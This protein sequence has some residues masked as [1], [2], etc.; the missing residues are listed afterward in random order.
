MVSNNEYFAFISY[1]REDEKWAEWLQHKLEHY[2]IPIKVR[3]ENPQL[4]QVIRPVFKDTSELAA[5]VLEEEIHEALVNSKYLIVI[6]S[7]RA[8]QSKWV[9]K[10]VQAFID[11][12]RSEKIIP[13][14]I[15]GTPYS[16]VP[17]EEC[18][19]MALLNLPKEQELLGVNINEMGR[20]AAAVKVVARMF[21]LKFDTLWQRFE[22]ERKK[23]RNI[24]WGSIITF[25]I[26]A[27]CISVW[28]W[29][30]NLMLKEKDMKIMINQSRAISGKA[31][32]LIEEGDSYTARLLLQEIDP[33]SNMFGYSFPYTAAW[34]S[35]LRKAD[36]KNSA[37]LTGHRQEV[38]SIC[39]S[40]DGELIASSDR[41]GDIIVWKASSGAI[42]K[43]IK[44]NGRL[45]KAVA[46]SPDGKLLA[47]GSNDDTIRFFNCETWECND[48]IYV[49]GCYLWAI[50]F[51]PDGKYLLSDSGDGHI[52][53]WNCK[54]LKQANVTSGKHNGIIESIS[55][56][57]DGT[58]FLSS[59]WDNN[60][61]IWDYKTGNLLQSLRGHTRG[62]KSAMFNKEGN[63]VVSG[64]E[65][66]TV[67]IWDAQT[68]NCLDTLVGHSD[69]VESVC[70]NKNGTKA[71]S[72]SA[73]HD[74]KIWN[75]KTHSCEEILSKHS[76]LINKIALSPNGKQLASA[77]N[78]CT[79]RLWDLE[80]N[81]SISMKWELKDSGR[82]L[83]FFH[84]KNMFIGSGDP[85]IV[86]NVETG[87]TLNLDCKSQFVSI[88]KDDKY[89]VLTDKETFI[90]YN[91]GKRCF[92]EPIKGH[93][94]Q[95]NSAIFS[96]DGNK[97]LTA[98]HDGEVKEWDILKG[99][100][101]RTLKGHTAEVLYASYSPDGLYAASASKEIKIWNMKTGACIDSIP[102]N[103]MYYRSTDFTKDGKRLLIATGDNK[104]FIWDLK[105]K[106]EVKA[107]KG[108]T[109]IVWGAF[110]N[111]DES[112]IISSSWDNTCII[113]D[114]ESGT[115]IDKFHSGIYCASLSNNNKWIANIHGNMIELREF[116]P[117]NSIME[118][119]NRCFKER[120]LTLEERRMYYL[121]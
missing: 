98:S 71:I 11:M 56:S 78:D 62:V 14:I 19:P 109:N 9:G 55:F 57:S 18:F 79:I 93:S 69:Y 104:I 76:K 87:D 89:A 74:I 84:R 80:N 58:K 33:Q 17:E 22:R 2:R 121:E 53:Y 63:L 3:K 27:I 88:S 103:D 68:G 30:Q 20:D 8:A 37:I 35:T 41:L 50:T 118:K 70:F 12:G 105:Q 38:K 92:S 114:T 72:A 13:F 28:I 6:C 115:I 83:Y 111:N 29:H 95:I 51:S 26:I 16:I 45:V 25:A 61:N 34:E 73:D 65:D 96:P 106:Q 97:I 36:K 86:C 85:T 101:I 81:D 110:F 108:H 91:I 116:L 7:P 23:R 107:Y 4:P 75:I 40:P 15:G 31:D 32:Q 64:S 77:S 112:R 48:S 24:I 43:I 54:N 10:E 46:F 5:G 39:Y 117:I 82:N 94:A 67:R 49:G 44:G 47:T 42:Y 113:W 59:S 90:V 21:E 100:C 99:R 52:A 120:K 66:K 1:K 60:I 119:T 102:V